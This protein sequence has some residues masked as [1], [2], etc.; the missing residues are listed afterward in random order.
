[1]PPCDAIQRNFSRSARTYDAHSL[2]QQRV[3]RRLLEYLSPARDVQ[4]LLEVGCGTGA[5]TALLRSRYP[6]AEVV[7]LDISAP[8]I[9]Q[10][11]IRP[12][13]RSVRFEVG[14]ITCGV[15]WG[16]FDLI[17]ANASLHWLSDLP[18]TLS[19]LAQA[20]AP[21]GRLGIS[22]FGPRTYWELAEVLHTLTPAALVPISRSFAPPAQWECWL[23][24]A[25]DHV[26]L[27]TGDDVEIYA[28]LLSL[29]RKIKYSGTQ[30]SSPERRPFTRGDIHRLDTCYRQR[31]GAIQATYETLYM[32]AQAGETP[33]RPSS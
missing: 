33:C 27:H 15:A 7:A 28:S 17:T 4:R 23:R 32:T 11:R 31:F 19:H 13:C 26:T 14:D 5:Y 3:G 22:V 30:G 24:A 10:A 25:F 21:G 18:V 1:M 20:L 12:S 9:E 8:M 29:L 6:E 2:V 16:T